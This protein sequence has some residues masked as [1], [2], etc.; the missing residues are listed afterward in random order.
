LEEK[1]I[2]RNKSKRSTVCISRRFSLE[3]KRKFEKDNN[4]LTKV[5]KLKRIEREGKKMIKFI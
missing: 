1:F 3:L 5:A 4:E 2:R